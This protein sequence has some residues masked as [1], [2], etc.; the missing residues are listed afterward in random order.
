MWK[1][2]ASSRETK[3]ICEW[4]R[5]V[6]DLIDGYDDERID[7]LL[8]EWQRGNEIAVEGGEYADFLDGDEVLSC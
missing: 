1:G 2:N 7:R 3:A 8:A 5:W 6:A 4:R